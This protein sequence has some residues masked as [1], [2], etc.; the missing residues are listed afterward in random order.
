MKDSD[1]DSLSADGAQEAMTTPQAALAEAFRVEDLFSISLAA[2]GFAIVNVRELQD[3]IMALPTFPGGLHVKRA[4]V[5]AILATLA[6]SS[7][8]PLADPTTYPPPGYH[9]TESSDEVLRKD[10]PPEPSR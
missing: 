4:D 3:R 9:F 1:I 7:P 5:L 6:T 8:E 2:A 10:S